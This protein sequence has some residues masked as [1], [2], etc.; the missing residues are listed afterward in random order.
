DARHTQQRPTRSRSP[1]RP[2]PGSPSKPARD[3]ET[4]PRSPPPTSYE[5]AALPVRLSRE[6]SNRQDAGGA[7][8]FT[9][10]YPKFGFEQPIPLAPWRFSLLVLRFARGLLGS[11]VDAVVRC[12]RFGV[13][14]ASPSHRRGGWPVAGRRAAVAAHPLGRNLARGDL[15]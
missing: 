4:S 7:R 14:R 10:K 11:R 2:P 15:R 13:Q 12:H 8:S 6:R 9:P 1:R 5:R 3:R